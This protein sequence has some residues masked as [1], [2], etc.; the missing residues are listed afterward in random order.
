VR[1]F[2][3][4]R[5][6]VKALRDAGIQAQTLASLLANPLPS[7]TGPQ[8]WF[9][10]ESSLASTMTADRVL[11]AARELGIDRFA[12][13]GDQ[14]PAPEHRGGHPRAPVPG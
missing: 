3:M 5:T 4:T 2:G 14:G 10:D 7:P 6:A 1:G 8:L 13:I 12:F 9:V 11:K